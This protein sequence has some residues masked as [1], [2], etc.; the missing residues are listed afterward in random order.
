MRTLVGGAA[1]IDSFFVTYPVAF[2]HSPLIYVSLGGQP[3]DEGVI[4]SARPRAGL[5]TTQ[6][7]VSL[8][9]LTA[10]DDDYDYY[11]LAIGPE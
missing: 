1:G 2:S 7:Q 3:D 9:H 8:R 5:A 6:M 4:I 11:W 10:V